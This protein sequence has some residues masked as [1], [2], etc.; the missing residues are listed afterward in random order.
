LPVLD[1]L[2]N[3]NVC[4][5]IANGHYLFIIKF[6]NVLSTGSCFGAIMRNC[7]L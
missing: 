3:N 6:E 5:S 1:V 7:K 2:A 4:Y